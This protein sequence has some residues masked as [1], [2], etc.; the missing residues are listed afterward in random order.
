M[1]KLDLTSGHGL[2]AILRGIQPDESVEI[3]QAIFDAGI[4]IVEVP[5]NSPDPLDS[6]NRISLAFGERMLIGAGTV[7]DVHSVRKVDQAGGKLIVSPNTNPVVIAEAK[8]LEMLSCPGVMTVSECFAALDAGADG[9]KLF[10]ASTMGTSFIG[11][12]RAVLPTGT[13]LIP[14]GGVDEH[15]IGNWFAAGADGFGL[16]TSIYKPG[17]TA[18]QVS[19]RCATIVSALQS[20]SDELA[21][22]RSPG[23][24][25]V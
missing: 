16:G 12:S 10:P 3:V 1:E 13:P 15:S 6:I 8:Q 20:C 7:L 5:L 11:A 19:E 4:R 18:K 14:V 21:G 22:H 23:H 2:I 17:M 25:T 9:L 24:G